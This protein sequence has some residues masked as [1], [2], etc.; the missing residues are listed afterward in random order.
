[1]G[2]SGGIWKRLFGGKEQDA[3]S[4]QSS[5]LSEMDGPLMTLAFDFGRGSDDVDANNSL[6]RI[7]KYLDKL[8]IKATFWCAAKLCE[9]APVPLAKI[10]DAGHEIGCLGYQHE[11]LQKLDNQMLSRVLMRC[12]EL[13]AKRG[14]HPAGYRPPTGTIDERI[15][16]EVARQGFKY[17]AD[18][19]PRKDPELIVAE[20]FPLVFMPIASNDS[21]FLRHPDE[22]HHVF[23]KHHTL[24]VKTIRERG[25]LALNYH[26]WVLGDHPGRIEDLLILIEKSVKAQMKFRPFVEALP[27]KYRPVVQKVETD[28]WAF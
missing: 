13:M 2:H 19:D 17:I 8:N 11:A 1:M 28:P 25:F 27:S 15:C 6:G 10:R 21:G 18:L 26:T 14:L 9:T 24:I 7:L 4:G 16:R 20:P 12:R 5:L 22:P 23:E 3:A